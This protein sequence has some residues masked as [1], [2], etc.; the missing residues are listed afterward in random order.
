MTKYLSMH[1]VARVL[2][3]CIILAGILRFIFR[4]QW[5]SEWVTSEG[6]RGSQM[7]LYLTDELITALL[8]IAGGIAIALLA[9][10]SERVNRDRDAT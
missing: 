3:V 8:T 9:G 2:S 4:M 6:P 1:A 5:Y 7:Y 10:I